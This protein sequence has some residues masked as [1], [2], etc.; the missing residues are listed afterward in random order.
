MK[1]IEV[2]VAEATGRVLDYLVERAIAGDE[3]SEEE[4]LQ[5]AKANTLRYST[6]WGRTGR[7][8]QPCDVELFIQPTAK[9]RH[10]AG[11]RD[12]VRVCSDSYLVSACRVIVIAK[13]GGVVPVP[14]G[15]AE[16]TS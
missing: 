1:M 5:A 2:K 10:G 16:L 8:L 11:I 3:Y 9:G 6:D 4:T 13:L 12:K 7:F 15:V 14:A